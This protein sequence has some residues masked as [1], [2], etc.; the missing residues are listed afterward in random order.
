MSGD[1]GDGLVDGDGCHVGIVR[2]PGA[3]DDER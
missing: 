3:V 2:D 1:V